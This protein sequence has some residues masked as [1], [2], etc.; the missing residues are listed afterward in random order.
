MFG[1]L[2]LNFCNFPFAVVVFQKEQTKF[3]VTEKF[4]GLMGSSQSLKFNQT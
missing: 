1:M 2:L 3:L 4:S